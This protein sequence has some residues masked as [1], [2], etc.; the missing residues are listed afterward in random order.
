MIYRILSILLFICTLFGDQVDELEDLLLNRPDLII[1]PEKLY[2]SGG[3]WMSEITDAPFT[4]RVE[5][6]LQDV[7]SKKVLECTLVKGLKHGIFIQYYDH[8]EKFSGI[9]GLYMK[10]MKEGGWVI[11][12]PTEGWANTSLL[13]LTKNHQDE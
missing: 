12:E 3:L 1:H 2:K 13:E 9:I 7:R 11:T 4:G 6:Y 8:L 5:I 10:D